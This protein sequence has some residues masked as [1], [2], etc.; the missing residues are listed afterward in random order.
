MLAIVLHHYSGGY[1]WAW[2]RESETYLWWNELIINCMSTSGKIGVDVFLMMTGYFL[3]GKPLRSSSVAK[4]WFQTVNWSYI[5]L[6]VAYYTSKV[7]RYQIKLS[8]FPVIFHG[9]W[10]V[11][12]YVGV[13][14]S[15]GWISAL[16][17]YTTP[18]QY[19]SGLFALVF[20]MGFSSWPLEISF[21]NALW[22]ILAV[23]VGAA[24]RKNIRTL[25]TIPTS[26]LI[27]ALL[28]VSVINYG[29]V[30]L[31]TFHYYQFAIDRTGPNALTSQNWSVLCLAYGTILILL[32][33]RLNFTSPYVN[34][35]ASCTLGVYLVHESMFI[36]P[37]IWT[38]WVNGSLHK[39]SPFLP[40]IAFIQ[41]S[42]VFLV[43]SF[44]EYIRKLVFGSFEEKISKFVATH[45]EALANRLNFAVEGEKSEV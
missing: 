27:A 30:Y 8:L 29:S 12:S 36:A 19:L 13:S 21:C 2:E 40:F 28:L 3:N 33:D 26:W 23:S 39:D 6:S 20:I 18:A 42:V 37:R 45:M 38:D 5:L 24:L 1:H 10:F 14:F 11:A 16:V 17:N 9:Y 7:T 4:T 15:T 43:C 25:R 34:R 41:V 31:F 44:L 22:F 35:V 32:T